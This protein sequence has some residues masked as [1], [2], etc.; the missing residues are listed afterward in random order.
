M[1]IIKG[2]FSF[3]QSKLTF[4]HHF[5]RIEIRNRQLPVLFFANKSDL[6]NSHSQQEI[7]AQMRLDQITDRPWHIQESNA[8]DG[9]G[10]SEGIN[11]LSEII[12][13]K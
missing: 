6:P 13:R 11:W 8:L 10:V 4:V 5:D 12:K 1:S 3:K 2:N 9:S 7:A